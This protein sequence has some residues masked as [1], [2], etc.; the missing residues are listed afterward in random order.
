M[1]ICLLFPAVFKGERLRVRSQWVGKIFVEFSAGSSFVDW[2]VRNVYKLSEK[3]TEIKSE[4]RYSHHP[5]P[6][7]PIQTL[8][9]NLCAYL[10]I[11]RTCEA[12]RFVRTQY[13]KIQCNAMQ[14]N[15]VQCNTTQHNKA[16][17]TIQ[18]NPIQY[19][20]LYNMLSWKSKIAWVEDCSKNRKIRARVD[21]RKYGGWKLQPGDI[22]DKVHDTGR[23][24]SIIR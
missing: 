21:S 13:H 2:A 16:P 24:R 14:C 17:N 1:D 15:A 7:S 5:E 22:Q 19:T 12:S 3:R 10:S 18:S 6:L 8:W 9:D 4:K 11:F 20:T 23:L